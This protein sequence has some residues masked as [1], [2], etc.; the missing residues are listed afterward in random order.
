MKIYAVADIH[1]AQYRIN[2]AYEIIK[3]YSPDVTCVCGDIT[4]FGPGD[5]AHVLLDQ[6][7]GPVFV[8]T[9]NIDT[10]DV[11]DGIRKSHAEDIHQSRVKFKGISFL[12]I[13]GVSDLETKRFIQNPGRSDLFDHLDVL[14]S[15]VPP[16]GFQDTVFLGKHAGSK[17]I[18]EFVEKWKPRLVLCGHI[19]ENPGFSRTD[20]TLIV[21]CSMGKRGKGALI[22]IDE[23]ISVN[24]LDY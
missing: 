23:D 9:G 4:Q 5:I 11:N 14:I 6:L 7:P 20:N 10:A 8:V 24:M 1:G 22:N 15:H 2:E 19:H 17:T 13:N 16:H 12:G 3:K 21:N 18:L